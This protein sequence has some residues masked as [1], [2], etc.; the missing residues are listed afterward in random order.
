MI[1]TVRSRCQLVRLSLIPEERIAA[2][3]GNVLAKEGVEP[4]AGVTNELARLARGSLRDA[5][6]ITDQLLA[7]VGPKPALADLQRVAPAGTAAEVETLLSRIEQGDRAAVLSA[8]PR[9]EGGESELCAALLAHLRLALLS[10]L[11]PAEAQLF[12]PSAELRAQMGERAKRLGPERMQIWMEELLH[13][14]E[15][16]ELLPQQARIVLELTLLDLCRPE[17]TLPLA[18]LEERLAALEHRLQG[19]APPRPPLAPP[20]ASPAPVRSPSAAPQA[21]PA[22]PRERAPDV[23]VPQRPP[24]AAPPPPRASNLPATRDAFTQDV[25]ELFSGQIEDTP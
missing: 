6:S 17:T 12:E 11:C 2:H 4:E 23:I 25:A 22:P 14:R 21:P 7:L 13:A 24:R 8:L 9:S 18:A 20:P 16:I 3:L 1:E 5:L 19:G 15:R 10:H